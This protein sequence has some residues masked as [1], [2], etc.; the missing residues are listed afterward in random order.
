MRPRQCWN[1]ET[2]IHP[3]LF[4]CSER[5]LIWK[6]QR[7]RSRKSYS[8]R[9]TLSP[10]RDKKRKKQHKFP[11]FRIHDLEE[12][13]RELQLGQREQ[14]EAEARRSREMIA[15]AERERMA[16]ADGFQ[17]RW[18]TVSGKIMCEMKCLSPREKKIMYD[19]GINNVLFFRSL[20]FFRKFNHTPV[21]RCFPRFWQLQFSCNTL[22]TCS[23]IIKSDYVFS[24]TECSPLRRRTLRLGRNPPTCGQNATDWGRRRGGRRREQGRRTRRCR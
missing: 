19:F 6:R 5:W 21:P 15:R 12:E 10:P 18:E 20:L 2:H 13:V 17:V 23:Q 7:Q 11:R 4:F 24:S 14:E 3:P 16:E 9:H 8:L 22:R 1:T